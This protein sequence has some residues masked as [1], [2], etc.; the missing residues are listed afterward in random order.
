MGE[1]SSGGI[2]DK[3]TSMGIKLGRLKTGTPPR[4]LKRS[5]EFSKTQ[6]QLG[7]DPP[8]YFT[9]WK[10]ELFHVEHGEPWL[11]GAYPRESMLERANGQLS[12]F[13]T[14]TSS[15][16]A[17]VI[18]EN[19][20]RSPLYS[21]VIK[22]VGPR[23]CPSI[24]DKIIKFPDKPKHQ[25]F[26]E[27]EGLHT[28]EYY[29]NGF[30]TSLPYEVQLEMIRTVG[31][32]ENAQIIRPAYAVEYDFAL[33]TQLLHSLESKSCSGLFFAGQIN[34]TSGYEEAA[35]QGLMAGINAARKVQSLPPIILG[36]DQAYIGVLIDDLVTKGASEPY[37]MFTSR[38]EYRL[39]LRQDNADARL[40]SIG[41][42]IGLISKA[43]YQ[44]Y[45]A[46]QAAI[47]SE[48][49][50][51]KKIRS[52]TETL[53]QLLRRPEISYADL[54]SRNSAL[55]QEIIQQIE[56]QVK[57]AGYIERQEIDIERLASL[58]GKGIPTDLNYSLVQG[59]RTEARLKLS[60][61]RPSSI[62]QASRISGISPA[63]VSVLLVYLRRGAGAQAVC[64]SGRPEEDDE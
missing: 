26:L 56:I 31:G 41:N 35:A 12:C 44:D 4:I 33:P 40:S 59:L 27:P 9:F 47:A 21:G 32:C 34:G 16:T 19:I 20:H 11:K 62:G 45:E 38:A 29:V 8:P 23:Y 55:S 51:I 50:R 61:L 15:R 18:R 39:L 64:D 6:R 36:R 57:Y 58:E 2:S 3:L 63:D 60:E 22:G 7:D 14:S 30:S 1:S 10:K 37:R 13:L 5:I 43:R 54:P 48:L 49:S 53:E 46:K 25:I 42:S 28:D 17:T 52:G 24:E